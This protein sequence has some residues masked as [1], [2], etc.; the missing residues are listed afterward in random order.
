MS[1]VKIAWRN[2]LRYKRRTALTAAL[3]II[4]VLMVIVFGGIGNSFKSEVIES[5]TSS[6]LG[7]FQI[8]KTGYVG[9]MDTLPLTMNIPEKAIKTIEATL[10]NNPEI[11]AFS[12]RIRFGAMISNY[13]QTTN[14]RLTAVDPAQE[15]ATCPGIVERVQD[16]K[17]GKDALIPQGT[18][19]IPQNIAQGMKLKVGSETVIIATNKDGSVNGMMLTVSGITENVQGP[20]GKDAYINIEDAR[21]ILRMESGEISEIAVRVKN[22]DKLEKTAA[23]VK[24]E[25]AKMGAGQNGKQMLELHTWSELSPFSSI[26]N[27]ISLLLLM[28]RFILLFIVLVSVLNVMTMSVYERIG[29]IGTIAAIGTSPSKIMGLFLTE[30]FAMG[31]L[32]SIAGAV[33]GVVTLLVLNAVKLPIRFGNRTYLIAPEIPYTEIAL[34]IAVVLVISL[35]ATLLPAIKAA[36]MEPVDALRHV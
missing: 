27:I 23:A 10:K 13:E 11:A 32:S 24:A 30:G 14:V 4:G 34:S 35:I 5:L 31:L 29:E 1:I 18:I 12:E 20:Q 21:T 22:F 9:S 6:N 7:D 28:T 17:T 2:L 25:L 19:L 36:K 33:L 8:H 26:A 15:T 3:I 16:G